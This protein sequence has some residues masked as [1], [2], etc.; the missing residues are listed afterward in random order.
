MTDAARVPGVHDVF[1]CSEPDDANS[2]PRKLRPGDGYGRIM[3]VSSGLG[4][5]RDTNSGGVPYG[6][7]KAT[8]NAMTNLAAHA[9]PP[10]VQ[11][12]TIC[13]VCVRTDTG[14]LPLHIS[15][16]ASSLASN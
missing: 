8:L 14:G 4:A 16:L 9:A 6:V 1:P 2:R 10:H 12:E 3:Y 13:T 5:L 15:R 7:L 11:A